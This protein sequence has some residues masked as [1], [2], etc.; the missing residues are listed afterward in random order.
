M[1]RPAREGRQDKGRVARQGKG[2]KG[3]AVRQ[4]PGGKTRQ[5]LPVKGM[6]ARQGK[7]PFLWAPQNCRN[8][9][10]ETSRI[11]VCRHVH[12]AISGAHLGRR[13][14]NIVCEI[15][16]ILQNS[17]VH[18][19]SYTASHPLFCRPSLAALALPGRPSHALRPFPCLDALPLGTPKL[20][21]HKSGYIPYRCAPTCATRNSR[22]TSGETVL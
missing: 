7:A 10:L 11:G 3:R 19:L 1:G 9:N 4:G 15:T 20:P 8:T 6:A 18:I 22:S 2:V 21:E 16:E 5:G 12:A 17:H 14:C 13:F